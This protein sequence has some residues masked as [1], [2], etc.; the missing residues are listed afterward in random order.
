ML[1]LSIKGAKG[2]LFTIAGSKD[3]SMHEV[4]EAAEV[5][6]SSVD[7]NAKVIFGAII[8]EA[9]NDEVKITVIAT[10]FNSAKSQI[11]DSES[12]KK[13]E[14]FQIKQNYELVG[15][16]PQIASRNLFSKR[17]SHKQSEEKVSIPPKTKEEEELEIP[18]FIRKK[19][20]GK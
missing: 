16:K 4:N 9:L 5:I 10:G 12:S 18:A 17:I 11:N 15:E 14:I 2:V 20:G 7:Q 19:M 1:E 13:E 8:D 3:L 6:T